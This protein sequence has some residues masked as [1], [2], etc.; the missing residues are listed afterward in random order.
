M[1][2]SQVAQ[3]S[4]AE[5]LPFKCVSQRKV[6]SSIWSRESLP[7]TRM[8]FRGRLVVGG[9]LCVLEFVGQ[10]NASQGHFRPETLQLLE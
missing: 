2:H 7:V 1:V 5:I 6:L 3:D 9:T 8:G 4:N 10:C